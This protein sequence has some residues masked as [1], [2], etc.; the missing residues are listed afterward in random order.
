[1]TISTRV[2]NRRS[3]TIRVAALFFLFAVSLHA[4]LNRGT[5][6]GSV[7]D[8]TRAIIP[9]VQVTIRNTATGATYQTATTDAGQY[10][11]P[12]LPPGLYEAVFEMQGLKRLVR[13]GLLLRVSEVLQLNVQLDLGQVT[14]TVSVTAEVPR[15]QTQAPGVGTSLSSKSLVD[16]PLSIGSA[17]IAE[18]FA[19]KIAPGVTGSAGASRMAGSTVHSK[20]TLL[21][22]ESVTTLRGGHFAE[23]SPSVEALAEFRVQTTGATAEFGRTQGGI[24]NFVMKSG[25]NQIHGSVFGALRNEA[26]NAN[27]FVNNSQGLPRAQDRRQNYA[28]SFGGPVY[29]PKVYNGKNRSFFYVAYERF[30]Q[31]NLALGGAP[32]TGPIPDFYDGNFSRL[33]GPV[34][35]QKD[36][37]G[38]DVLRGAIFDPATFRRLDSG[39]WVGDMF[40][41]NCIPISRFSAV[42]RNLNAIA[43][44]QYVPTVRDASGQIALVNNLPYPAVSDPVSDQYQFSVKGDHNISSA[45]K[46]SGSFSETL[47]PRWL[48]Q[49]GMWTDTQPKGGVLSQGGTQDMASYLARLA[50]DWIISSRIVNYAGISF[51]RMT[52]W[53]K[54]FDTA[55]DGAAALGIKGLSTA[56]Y[57][58]VNWGGGP[59]V[60]LDG[61]GNTNNRFDAWTSW[62]VRDTV[63]LSLGRHFL[64]TGF[65]FRRNMLNYAT[66]PNRAF[67]FNAVSTAIPNEAFAGNQTGFSFAGYLLGIVYSADGFSDSIV[68]SDRRYYY[69]AFI[70][71]DF[72]VNSR[73]TLQLGLRWEYSPPL[74]EGTNRM[75]AWSPTRIDPDS[76][77]PGAYEFAGHC[78]VCV[79][80]DY[81]GVR[82]LNNLAPRVGFAYRPANRLTLR[83]AY[84]IFYDVDLPGLGQFNS[85][86][87][88]PWIGSVN[89]SAD[90]LEPW[91]GTF[92]WDGGI[93]NHR[94][95]PPTFDASWGN[96]N[97]PT[98]VDPAYGVS[99]YSQ[100]WNFNIQTELPARMVLD[101][102]YIGANGV[103][104]RNG[105]LVRLN[106]LRP[107]H[108]VQYGTNLARTIRTP[109]DA[110]ANGISY[111]YQ[112]FV[113]TV[114][115]ALRPYPQVQGNQTITAIGSPEGFSTYHSMQVVLDKEFA[116]GLNAYLNYVWAKTL[117]NSNTSATARGT[118]QPVML[119]YY[120]RGLEKTL[121]DGDIPHAFKAFVSYELP[122]GRGRAFLGT[123]DRITNALLGGWSF[124][125]I[126]NYFSGTPVRFSA[127]SPYSLWNG[128]TNRPNVLP[129]ELNMDFSKA[130]FEYSRASSPGSNLR[131][132]KSKFSDPG[133]LRLG[134]G[135]ASYSQVRNFGASSEDFALHKN[136]R[137]GEKAR[138][139]LRAE[140]I[141]VFNRSILGG[142]NT[143][144]NSPLFGQ[145]TNRS[146]NRQIQ[147]GVR[148]D[149]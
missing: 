110:A 52:Q 67:N 83:G 130:Q 91:R 127:S 72:K 90:P 4:Q 62:G 28:F 46:L 149:F 98:M 141:N 41:G 138:L 125:A 80:R 51:N 97:K 114:A 34:I 131:L 39:R 73:L 37:L 146:G 6:T 68:T 25:T 3:F 119:D 103:K 74:F 115:S 70:Q 143:S 30:R 36:A 24:M 135:A 117:T 96:K 124:S 50:H 108:L 63:S 16:L 49:R 44:A 102:G 43:K 88:F 8:P 129:G 118:D 56:G 81:F 100:H 89:L 142:L 18:D 93:P 47:R 21:D 139:Q 79:G 126:L 55:V 9:R 75:A 5:I 20:E 32:K 120:N 107:A 22:G 69:S 38:R 17:R 14:D 26:L 112:G 95:V 53:S 123:P 99:P 78:Q 101:I 19:F 27:T 71:D 104:L 42:S 48:I 116:H 144:V 2:D 57:P 94:Y 33:L 148:V 35:P 105:E 140:F 87:L 77:L 31:R 133:T 76:K 7:T 40:S 54:S 137:L 84:G 82:D 23:S 92:N 15:L 13:D 45:H 12:N 128:G 122:V 66:A 121:S 147:F 11:A 64:K 58:T 134:T 132:D 65:D 113:G 59:F 60:S 86:W 85:A 61:V 1:M 111:P 109:A 29:V 10:S 106:Q 136:A 145:I